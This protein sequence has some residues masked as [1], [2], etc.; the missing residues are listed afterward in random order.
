MADQHAQDTA[1]S[2]SDLSADQQGEQPTSNSV[3]ANE[4]VGH[5]ASTDKPKTIEAV[6][7]GREG[8]VSIGREKVRLDRHTLPAFIQVLQRIFMEVS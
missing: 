8:V 3:S 4:V 1:R 7:D 6:R 2:S 5:T